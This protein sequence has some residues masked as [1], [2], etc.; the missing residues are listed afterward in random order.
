MPVLASFGAASA[1]N[2]GFSRRR[3]GYVGQ[4][5]YATAGTYSMT[6]P[7]GATK[8][9]VVMIGG[10]AAG[11]GGYYC[12]N[13]QGCACICCRT[14]TI[15]YAYAEGGTGGSGGNLKYKNCVTVVGGQTLSITV[16]GPGGTSSV[17]LGGV[18]IGVTASYNGGSGSAGQAWCGMRY[19][20]APSLAGGNGGNAAGYSGN[21]ANASGYGGGG[22]QG[23]R[24]NSTD[25]GG[26]GGSTGG[27]G[28]GGQV[29]GFTQYGGAS[30]NCGIV[31]ILFTHAAGPTRQFPSTN[32]GDL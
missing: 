5:V 23:N 21:G 26:S 10:G 17:S 22:Q 8:M 11:Q 12:G 13:I 30:G 16:G 27:G 29:G 2:F 19:Q 1:K 18:S 7:S 14:Y 3:G 20:A 6:V 15:Y 31:R 4:A 9:S 25:S 32:I 28:G 24:G